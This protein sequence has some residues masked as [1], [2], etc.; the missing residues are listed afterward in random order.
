[1]GLW[2]G[3]INSAQDCV[4]F[5]DIKYWVDVFT[6]QFFNFLGKFMFDIDINQK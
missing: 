1:M 4:H 3:L 2:L 6:A 5:P